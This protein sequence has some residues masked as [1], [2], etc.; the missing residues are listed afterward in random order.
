MKKFVMFNKDVYKALRISCS[1][2][3]VCRT[4]SV[5]ETISKVLIRTCGIQPRRNGERIN[6]SRTETKKSELKFLCIIFEVGPVQTSLL[7]MLKF[8][9]LLPDAEGLSV[10]GRA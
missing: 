2:T 1:D 9:K 7:A 8:R 5:K 6:F 10:V 3:V 4:S